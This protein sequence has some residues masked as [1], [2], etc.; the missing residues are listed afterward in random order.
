MGGVKKEISYWST[1]NCIYFHLPEQTT[2][3]SSSNKP[4]NE[5]VDNDSITEKSLDLVLSP[6]LT[7][8][9]KVKMGLKKCQPPISYPLMNP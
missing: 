4:S 2:R 9:W 6:L 8:N 7:V 1:G 3:F 5:T